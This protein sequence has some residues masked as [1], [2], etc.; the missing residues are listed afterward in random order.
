METHDCA[1][2]FLNHELQNG[3]DLVGGVWEMP[4]LFTNPPSE[5]RNQEPKSAE[6]I[7]IWSTQY[8]D[9]WI[10]G[11]LRHQKETAKARKREQGSLI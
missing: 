8:L 9:Y 10:I 11:I 7:E 2:A 3:F 6:V 1:T 5:Q 4:I